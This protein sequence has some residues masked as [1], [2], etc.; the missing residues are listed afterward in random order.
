MEIEWWSFET[1]SPAECDALI[2]ELREAEAEP[3]PVYGLGRAAVVHMAT[4]RTTKLIPSEQ[5]RAMVGAALGRL[6]EPLGAHFNV[7]LTRC[8]EPQFLR[9]VAGD[10]FVAHQ[11]GN[12][13]MIFD[14]SRHR[15]VSL[16]LFLSDRDSYSGGDLLFHVSTERVVAP[17]ARGTAIAFRSE[18]THE[19]TPVIE[20]ERY[21]VVT[22]YR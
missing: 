21:T 2:A 11:D 10:Y 13:G 18:Q 20:G 9:Y 19:V 7:R 4:R 5:T 8:E 22:W 6:C 14:D 12:T 16:T 17:A 3:A 1:F 15:R